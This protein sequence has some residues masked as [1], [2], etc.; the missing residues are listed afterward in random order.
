MIK[1]YLR[2]TMSQDRFTN[3]AI[4]S[5]ENEAASSIDFS[6]VVIKSRKVRF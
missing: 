3:R 6:G 4:L 5:V 1:S 2:S